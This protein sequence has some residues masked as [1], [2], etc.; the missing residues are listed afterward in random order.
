MDVSTTSGFMAGGISVSKMMLGGGGN[1]VAHTL[2]LRLGSTLMP[3]SRPATADHFMPAGMGLGTSVPLVTPV[4]SPE[5]TPT[6]G[7]TEQQ[8]FRRP[9]GRLLIFWGCGTHAGPGQPVIIDFSKMGQQQFPPGLFSATV[10]VEPGPTFGNSRTYGDWPNGKSGKQP[11]P[12]SSLLGEHR[13]AGNYNPEIK[14]ALDQDF[15]S[16]LSAQTQAQPDGS[17]LLSWGP[18]DAATGY[19]A[20]LFG[21]REMGDDN[22]DM[23]WWTSAASREFGAGLW[24]WL[25]PATVSGLIARRV[26]MPPRQTSCAIPAEVKTAASGFM[27]AQLYAYGPERNFAYPPRPANPKAPWKPDWTARV[28]YRSTTSLMLGMPGMGDNGDGGAPGGGS[29][30]QPKPKKKCKPSL[31][32]LMGGRIC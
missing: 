12:A 29:A 11:K 32:G 20:W 28:R 21:A 24:D 1:S 2:L 27:L 7:A 19:Y 23:V 17:Q 22:A 10:P 15:M 6:P 26:V 30:D 16:A 13:V 14:F 9:K 3:T 4:P 18:V 8:N 5:A 25:P 31:G